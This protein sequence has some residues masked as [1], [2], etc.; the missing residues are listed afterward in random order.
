MKDV[1]LFEALCA[2]VSLVP[3]AGT[4]SLCDRL[5]ALAARSMTERLPFLGLAA[6]LLDELEQ[7][8]RAGLAI[9][10]WMVRLRA[11]LLRVLAGATGYAAWR[12]LVRGLDATHQAVV[13]ASIEALAESARSDAMRNIHA[14]YHPSTSVRC[15]ALARVGNDAPPTLL[16]PMLA[17]DATAD[18]V[19]T[20]ALRRA[21]ES[22]ESV[23]LVLKLMA[24]G[25]LE[26]TQATVALAELDWSQQLEA[27]CA[28]L[29]FWH[30]HVPGRFPE[31]DLDALWHAIEETRANRDALDHLVAALWDEHAPHTGPAV[32]HCH[33]GLL[34]W[35]ERTDNKVIHERLALSTM[36]VA[37]TR[38]QSGMPWSR[39][40]L[41]LAMARFP[42]LLADETIDA[43]LRREAA[44]LLARH[45]G[46]FRVADPLAL[47]A[48]LPIMRRPDG[49]P[50]L[51]L[52]GAV[53][54]LCSDKP[55][56]CLTRHFTQDEVVQALRT[57]PVES[58]TLLAFESR[59][60][61]ERKSVQA[62]MDAVF[63]PRAGVPGDREQCALALAHIASVGRGHVLRVLAQLHRFEG[64]MLVAVVPRLLELSAAGK[65]PQAQGERVA[66]VL[67]A[68]C[69]R[70]LMP[71]VLAAIVA[72]P[73]DDAFARELMCAIGRAAT[74]GSFVHAVETL[75]ERD[76][77]A[78][79]RLLERLLDC[80]SF[81]YGKEQALA[82]ELAA[83]ADARVRDWCA[84]ARPAEL[85]DEASAA[86]TMAAASVRGEGVR[87]L[88]EEEVRSLSSC[89]DG[90]LAGLVRLCIAQPRSGLAQALRLR[91]PT[92]AAEVE[93][94]LG[95]L[96]DHAPLELVDALL[97]ERYA[98]ETEAFVKALDREMIARMQRRSPMPPH[99]NAWLMLW[100]THQSELMTQLAHAH[101]GDLGAG[102]CALLEQAL[103]VRFAPL[104]ERMARAVS[105]I[106]QR[107][108]WRTPQRMAQVLSARLV[109]LCASIVL[110][111]TSEQRGDTALAHV[112]EVQQRALAADGELAFTAAEI[113]RVAF[114]LEVQPEALEAQR[115]VLLTVSSELAPRIVEAL[116]R[117]L[118]TRGL[119]SVYERFGGLQR[120]ASADEL[121]ELRACTDLEALV[122]HCLG[123]QVTLAEEAALRLATEFGAAGRRA[124]LEAVAHEPLCLAE[125][126]IA[127][128]FFPNDDAA[129]LERARHMADALTEGSAAQRFHVSLAL[130][131]RGE[132]RAA[133]VLAALCEPA[134]GVL[135]FR[136]TDWRRLSILGLDELE[137]ARATVTSPQPAAY[138]RAVQTLLAA[139]PAERE[140]LRAF[141]TCDSERLPM[142]RLEVAERLH[143]LGDATGL[144]VRVSETFGQ[145]RE[146]Q[147]RQLLCGVSRRLV[148]AVTDAVLTAGQAIADANMLVDQLLESGVDPSARHRAM[149]NIAR[150]TEE[151]KARGRALE[152]LRNQFSRQLKLRHLAEVFAWGAELGREL[153]GRL[154]TVDL[155][156]DKLGYTRLNEQ[157]IVVNPLPLLRGE[158]NGRAVVEALVAHEIGHHVYHA[159]AEGLALW[160]R[161]G[162]EH[163][164]G[165]FNLV[166]DEHLERNLRA[167]R[168]DVGNALKQLASYAFQHNER[169]LDVAMLLRQLGARAYEVL[170][171]RRLGV[172]RRSGSV[173]LVIG[174]VF[175]ELESRG[176]SFSRFVRALRMGLG[177]RFSD[178][179][180]AEALELFRG[181]RFR[182]A[183]LQE[184]YGIAERLREMFG[185]EIEILESLGQDGVFEADV[186]EL[187]RE[188]EGISSSEIQQEIERIKNPRNRGS[189]SREGRSGRP[190]R[191]WINVSEEHAFER[192]SRVVPLSHDPVA[193][194][195]LASQVARHSLRMR[196]YFERMGLRYEPQGA[197]VRGRAVDRSRIES[198]VVRGDPRVLMM[199]EPRLRTDLFLGIVVDCSGSMAIGPSMTKARLFATL[200]AEAAAGLA[201]VDVRVF[202]FTD[203]AIYDAGDA[204]RCAAH[205]MEADG[206]NNDAAGLWHAAQVAMASRRKARLLVMISDGLPTECSVASLRELVGNLTRRSRICCA[207][208]A[209]RPLTEKCFDHYVEVLETDLDRSVREFA[210]IIARLVFRTLRS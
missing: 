136:P 199:R 116:E 36:R 79:L 49:L 39:A 69:G 134:A 109:E 201:G 84:R 123:N 41:T 76:A 168:E 40:L 43:A 17:D 78:Q 14:L 186:G 196:S 110:L 177:D 35:L 140:A 185:E 169:E 114:E 57:A 58:A 150:E 25:H 75:G 8:S 184:L 127:I 19:R 108:R 182:S 162:R 133:Q 5:E 207:Q 70:R 47:V 206:G 68:Q 197:R 1:E 175:G 87:A 50:D 82:M 161:A 141:L 95:L 132:A 91:L 64:E 4:D 142:L 10:P 54:C 187:E 92:R 178:P 32:R 138:T 71:E 191:L 102:L 112:D 118:Q 24:C 153:T 22:V 48:R 56:T 137:L 180:V 29:P 202:G 100:E 20:H 55:L 81:P 152:Q 65:L 26:V 119:R 93:A 111:P 131:E 183:S 164:T 85:D 129:S 115:K 33:D 88:D 15:A 166:L 189:G 121:A 60:E 198:L 99:G 160:E 174:Q 61:D 171:E 203:T 23:P 107:L 46:P 94:A 120:G 38:A 104:R 143:Q 205:A 156:G 144:C 113:L 117:W 37:R 139:E 2:D 151:N 63:T 204:T 147:S 21:L 59:T 83:H 18:Q 74:T 45:R 155:C 179:R 44:R 126:A 67:A 11:A 97:V 12:H 89:P 188:T 122:S 125:I 195:R 154:F 72:A 13:A 28:T 105:K 192:I 103:R 27:I 30:V 146:R 62:L 128:A 148:V 3:G 9:A 6:A 34:T 106:L 210:G 200:L 181:K 51:A 66:E 73:A 96:V 190:S 172:A 193:H 31:D 80:G 209:V 159:S 167:R 77:D 7:S 101:D 170:G 90:L 176:M 52:C 163:L 130:C 165:V 149:I 53:L 173:R 145:R 194:R 86:A 16:L 98:E 157:R 208:V 42:V 158:Q 135:W 124:L